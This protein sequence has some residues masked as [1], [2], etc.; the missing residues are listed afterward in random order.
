MSSSYKWLMGQNLSHYGGQWIAVHN[1][2]IIARGSNLKTVMKKAKKVLL[3][4]LPLY[5]RIPEGA[6][7]R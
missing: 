4:E 2:S 6:I 7:M 1:K 3:N 5:Y